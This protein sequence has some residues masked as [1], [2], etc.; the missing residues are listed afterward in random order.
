VKTS[1]KARGLERFSPSGERDQAGVSAAGRL[2]QR[3]VRFGLVGSTGVV[4]DMGVLFLLA[5]QHTL[6]WGI[7]LSKSLAAE[8]AIIN[9]FTWNEVFTFRD[10][11]AGEPGSLARIG[12]FG[13]FNLICL[14]GIGI[15][16][17]SLNGEIRVLHLNL[18]TANLIAIFLASIWNFFMSVKFGWRAAV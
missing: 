1:L 16:I 11:S 15:G 2:I 5:D 14:M 6:G 17:L 12:R 8:V 18:Y 4:V 10:I 7:M 9:N 13:R 3:F